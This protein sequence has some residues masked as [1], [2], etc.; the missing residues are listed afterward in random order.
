MM[1]GIVHLDT[2]FLYCGATVI[3]PQQIL[4][5]IHCVALYKRSSYILGVIVGAHN[6]WTST[7]KQ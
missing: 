7:F 2:R 3:T 6:T 5:A 1:A 4:T